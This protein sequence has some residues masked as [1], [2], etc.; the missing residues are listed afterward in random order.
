MDRTEAVQSPGKDIVVKPDHTRFQIER[1]ATTRVSEWPT[2]EI[3]VC[4]WCWHPFFDREE[5]FEHDMKVYHGECLDAALT[6][7]AEVEQVFF[8]E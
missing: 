8:R 6:L 5:R 2:E 7:W 1:R 3:R 4:S